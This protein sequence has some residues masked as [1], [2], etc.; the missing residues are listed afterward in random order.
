MRSYSGTGTARPCSNA[1]RH[2]L[3]SLAAPRPHSSS[4]PSHRFAV[5]HSCIRGFHT[6][7]SRGWMLHGRRAFGKER[8]EHGFKNWQQT[9][10]FLPLSAFINSFP[11]VTKQ[12][13]TKIQDH[14]FI[15][16]LQRQGNVFNGPS[17]INY[18]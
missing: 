15:Y 1:A 11:Q 14:P 5:A 2:Q 18:S 16:K 13:T 10:G 7:P 4:V 6:F 9:S 12:A 3:I 17:D 8:K